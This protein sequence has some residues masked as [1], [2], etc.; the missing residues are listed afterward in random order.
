MSLTT[1]DKVRQR[2]SIEEYRAPDTLIDEFIVSADGEIAYRLGRT[3]V[4]ADDDYE[5]ACATATG[6]AALQTGLMLPYP[7]NSNEAEAWVQKLKMIRGKTSADMVHLASELHT[8][9]PMPR[10]TTED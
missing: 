3:P 4:A 10:S 1:P 7:E 6:L 5:F 9:T 8:A 2:L